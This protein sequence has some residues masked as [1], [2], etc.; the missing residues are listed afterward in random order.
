M[1][2]LFLQAPPNAPTSLTADVVDDSVVLE[3][4]LG[5]QFEIPRIYRGGTVD[6]PWD[7]LVELPPG[8][9][10]FTDDNLVEDTYYYFVAALYHVV[11]SDPSNVVEAIVG[12]IIPAPVAAFSTSPTSAVEGSTLTF[13]NE[14]TGEIDAY[15]WYV[16]DV[17]VATTASLVH[18]F[19]ADGTF[20]IKLIVF[21]PG[22]SDEEEKLGYVTILN[23][24][25]PIFVSAVLLPNGTTLQVTYD[26]T[27]TGHVGHIFV[28]GGVFHSPQPAYVTGEGTTTLEYEADAIVYQGQS[29]RISYSSA[30]GDINHLGTEVQSYTSFEVDN[31]STQT[32][33][34]VT[35]PT[36]VSFTINIAG[37]QGTFVMSEIVTGTSG[38]TISPSGGAA[39]LGYAGGS[40]TDEITVNISRTILL[41]ETGSVGYSP[42]NVIDAASN[43]LLTVSGITFDNDSEAEAAAPGQPLNFLVQAGSDTEMGIYWDLADRNDTEVVVE[44]SLNGTTGWTVIATLAGG[45]E[46]W[47][48]KTCW[49]NTEFFYRV[50]ARN[51]TGDS[52]YT[53]VMSATTQASGAGVGPLTSF[54]VNANS[55]WQISLSGVGPAS[56]SGGASECIIEAATDG[57]NFRPIGLGGVAPS[58][59]FNFPIGGLVPSTE[60][61]FR[62]RLMGWGNYS[63]YTSRIAATTQ[64]LPGGYADMPRNIRAT[65][66]SATQTNITWD[67]PDG[68]ATYEIYTSPIPGSLSTADGTYTKVGETGLGASSFMLTTVAKTPVFLRMRSAK[69]GNFSPYSYVIDA[70]ENVTGLVRPCSAGSAATYHIGP[71]QTYTTF[72]AFFAA[73]GS[74]GPG[75]GSTIYVHYAT[76]N[77]KFNIDWR[78]LA[79]ARITIE[80]VPDGSGNLPVIDF[81]NAVTPP[82]LQP[83]NSYVFQSLSGILFHRL[84]NV[85]GHTPGY[86]TLKNLEL[87]HSGPSGGTCVA[88]DGTTIGYGTWP[89]A[90][91]VVGGD[92]IRIENCDING[93]ACGIFAADAG[94]CT[95]Q[96]HDIEM[97]GNWFHDNGIPGSYLEH[98]TY[99]ECQGELYVGNRYT[100]LRGD[101]QGGY[102]KTRGVGVRVYANYFDPYNSLPF[103]FVEHQNSHYTAW[104]APWYEQ[105]VICAGN[106]ASN[107]GY[108]STPVRFAGDQG[109]QQGYRKGNLHFYHNTLVEIFDSYSRSG[110]FQ[111]KT[112]ARIVFAK[113][114]V[115]YI[116]P[117]TPSGSAPGNVKHVPDETAQAVKWGKNWFSPNPMMVWTGEWTGVDHGFERCII[118][119][120]NLPNFVDRDSGNYRILGGT[121]ADNRG[122]RLPDDFPPLNMEFDEPRGT[123]SRALWGFGSD[124]GA[125]TAGPDVVAPTVFSATIDEFGGILSV[126]TSELI[127]TD[128]TGWAIDTTGAPATLTYLDGSGT[129]V[130]RF[131]ISRPILVTDIVTY[132]YDADI[133]N[134]QDLA[135]SP[136]PMADIVGEDVINLSEE[137]TTTGARVSGATTASGGSVTVISLPKPGTAEDGDVFQVGIYTTPYLVTVDTPAGWTLN[138]EVSDGYGDGKL[139]I[140]T[141]VIPDVDA[142]PATFDFT[143]PEIGGQYVE[144][145]LARIVEATNVGNPVEDVQI[146]GGVVDSTQ[147]SP[148]VTTLG[149]DRLIMRWGALARDFNIGNPAGHIRKIHLSAGLIYGGRLVLSVTS[150]ASAGATGT[151]N[152]TLS[153]GAGPQSRPLAMVTLAVKPE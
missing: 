137:L 57:V 133:G 49:A 145:A 103:G 50:L 87:T 18:P 44:K 21:G 122:D 36:I 135:S 108:S 118:T 149:A 115:R 112:A 7:V 39:T 107:I 125:L 132:D 96:I 116:A 126:I 16:D 129:N 123:V 23:P 3:W 6:G 91:Y 52:A 45:H 40:G 48:D 42:G 65:V 113:N 64:A 77:V 43:P 99:M 128:G 37:T 146:S 63:D 84:G 104:F 10:T 35:A 19:P 74:A 56:I 140:Y 141:K 29:A 28:A 94:Q 153:T 76:Y 119:L 89:N 75:P 93:G 138:A 55:A 102:L 26:Q 69:S 31:Q 101:T 95:R 139:R 17:L 81:Y 148:G 121:E 60:Y 51:A 100:Q 124:L 80:G 127:T 13:T 30:S 98:N 9:T 142:E 41:G 110:F 38:F 111:S 66:V 120:T 62:C 92:Y 147:P 25:S 70:K 67:N 78:G 150:A 59:A 131:A 2:D 32:Q 58:T 15:E 47:M 14:S 22:G 105:D 1:A 72:A 82:G 144:G 61:T 20:D 83:G 46:G 109:F 86:V 117:A 27:V 134:V 85:P 33:G 12:N 5:S 68:T 53:E 97:I 88:A 11:P 90:I 71:G 106:I 4:N 130:I 114:N 54:A 8:E 136:N 79:S 152:F 143:I 151:A 34:D 73:V 24:V